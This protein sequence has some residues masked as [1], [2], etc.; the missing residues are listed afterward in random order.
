MQVGAASQVDKQRGSKVELQPQQV[1]EAAR[2]LRLVWQEGGTTG[3]QAE[4]RDHRAVV[5]VEHFG[6]RR[7]GGLAAAWVG[8]GIVGRR[9]P[10]GVVLHDAAA[11]QPPQ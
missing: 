9:D 1:R 2:R 7:G 5:D 4:G 10:R 6:G 11:A 8:G 3:Q